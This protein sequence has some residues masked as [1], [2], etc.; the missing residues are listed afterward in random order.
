MIVNILDCIN[1]ETPGFSFEILPPIKGRNIQGIFNNIEALL[2]Y[3]PRFINVTTHRSEFVFKNLS[4]GLYQRVSE[5]ARPGTVAVAAAI[6]NKFDIPAIPH[7][8]CSGFTPQETEYALIDLSFLGITNLLVLRG[9]KAKHEPRF[10]PQEGGYSHASELQGQINKFNDGLLLDGSKFD[11]QHDANFIYGVAG[12]PEKHEESPNADIDLLRLKDK[13]DSGASYIVTQLFYD[14]DK[15]YNFVDNCRKV[16]INVPII[17][18]IK[19]FVS[20]GQLSVIPKT[21]KVDLPQELVEMIE[22]AEDDAAV[23]KAG[24]QW[25]IQQSEDLIA[26]GFKHIHYYS[27]NSAQSVKNIVDAIFKKES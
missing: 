21:F 11:L 19:P 3:K 22:A 25:A 26:N 2:S 7:M 24:V 4:D 13:V 6:Q 5:R 1:S 23:K 10:I 20:K 9:D 14:N 12:Y 27:H 18:G 16:G 17:P 8:I 15:F